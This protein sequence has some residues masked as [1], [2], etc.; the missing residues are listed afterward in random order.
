MNKKFIWIIVIIIMLVGTGVYFALNRQLSPSSPQIKNFEECA[1]AGYP[2]GES[3][4]R[5]CW[6]P[7]GKHFVENTAEGTLPIPGPITVSGEITCLPKKGSGAQT[8]ECAL[9]LKELDGR[10][11][12]LKN[13]FKLDPEYKFSVGGLRVEVSGTFN[14]EEMKGPDG[15]KYDVV[16]VIDVT[17][18]KEIKN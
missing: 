4:P 9:G 5:Q 1:H 13:L 2:V 10:H 3:Y 15:N 14:P 12:G 11:Y 18:I 16:G 17:S 8:M 7:D 6:T